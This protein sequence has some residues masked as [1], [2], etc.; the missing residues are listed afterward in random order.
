MNMRHISQAE[1]AARYPDHQ[2]LLGEPDA[3][4]YRQ[5]LHPGCGARIHQG[6]IRGGQIVMA[7][8]KLGFATFTPVPSMRRMFAPNTDPDACANLA[9][10]LESCDPVEPFTGTIGG[11]DRSADLLAKMRELMDKL[12]K[13]TTQMPP[14]EKVVMGPV[15]LAE[16]RSMASFAVAPKP[17]PTAVTQ[18]MLCGIQ[19]LESDVLEPDQWIAYDRKGRIVAMGRA[20]SVGI[21]AMREPRQP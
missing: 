11:P 6:D 17:D 13:Y 19:I 7:D 5:C 20:S 10:I 14:A 21:F 16:L 15:A 12:N 2:H 9:R 3:N 1:A 18:S 8:A 4:G